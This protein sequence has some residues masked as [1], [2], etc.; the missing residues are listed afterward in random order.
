MPFGWLTLHNSRKLNSAETILSLDIAWCPPACCKVY[1]IVLFHGVWHWLQWK[2]ANEHL[3]EEDDSCF[4]R[5][6]WLYNSKNLRWYCESSVRSGML[7]NCR[8]IVTIARFFFA[9]FNR[10]VCN[11]SFSSSTVFLISCSSS[12]G[13]GSSDS[14]FQKNKRSSAQI[15]D[16]HFEI[17]AKT[18]NSL[19]FFLQFNQLLSALLFKLGLMLPQIL[20][21]NHQ[22]LDFFMHPK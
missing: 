19:N 13:V 15:I 12:S 2:W 14:L 8:S 7:S 3:D 4:F 17:Y 18:I 10:I 1:K 5:I 11:L 9:S 20:I 6:P 21:F 16:Y 22:L